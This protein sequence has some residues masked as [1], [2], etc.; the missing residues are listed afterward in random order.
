MRPAAS[1]P[2]PL[3][4][5]ELA[6]TARF[7]AGGSAVE[8]ARPGPTTTMRN[9]RHSVSLRDARWVGGNDRSGVQ[10]AAKVAVLTPR[11]GE[12]ASLLP[13]VGYAPERST[14]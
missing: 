10:A 13:Q 4:A 11:A 5:H 1:E 8:T 2:D 3:A 7:G 12:C 14:G 9:E 6:R